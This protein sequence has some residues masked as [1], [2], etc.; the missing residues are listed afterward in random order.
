MKFPF[1]VIPLANDYSRTAGTITMESLKFAM[2][3]LTQMDNDY[4]NGECARIYKDSKNNKN[5]MSIN[6]ILK[7]ID[8]KEPEKTLTEAN[9]WDLD[10]DCLNSHGWAVLSTILVEKYRTELIERANK[11]IEAVKTNPELNRE[12]NNL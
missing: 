5:K 2:N 10:K 6:R 1:N 12:F 7:K 8:L 3:Q 4:L 9:L 11:I